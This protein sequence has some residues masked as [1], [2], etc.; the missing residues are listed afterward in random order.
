M[1]SA[2]AVNQINWCISYLTWSVW[3]SSR[4]FDRKLTPV[5]SYQG[6]MYVFQLFDAYAASG[7][8]LLFVAIFESICI[9][10]VYGKITTLIYWD[11][12]ELFVFYSSPLSVCCQLNSCHTLQRGWGVRGGAL[13]LQSYFFSALCWRTSSNTSPAKHLNMHIVWLRY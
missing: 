6:G 9:G 3:C 11:L 7:M 12:R 8:C 2:Q 5:S 10:W 1:T 13:S 4:G